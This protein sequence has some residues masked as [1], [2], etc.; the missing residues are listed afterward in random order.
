MPTV[1]FDLP[2]DPNGV[3]PG[4]MP[5]LT[6]TPVTITGVVVDS[7][8]S[9]YAAA[10]KAVIRDGTIFDPVATIPISLLAAATNSQFRRVV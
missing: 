5:M 2:D 6:R 3:E 4:A 8:G 1:D 7:P 9:G 10:P